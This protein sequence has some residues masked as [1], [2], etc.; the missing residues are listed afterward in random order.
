MIWLT[1]VGHLAG[2]IVTGWIWL[3]LGIGIGASFD[4]Q[5][6][7]WVM[8]L[9]RELKPFIPMLALF[10]LLMDLTILE[11]LLGDT[12][13][14]LSCVIA[15]WMYVSD[16]DDDDRWKRRRDKAAGKIKSLGHKLVVAPA[17]G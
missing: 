10:N 12:M 15:L 16:K 8:T 13:S 5:A 2:G 6:A 11:S 1:V 7:D 9:K 4:R 17:Q 3:S 14:V